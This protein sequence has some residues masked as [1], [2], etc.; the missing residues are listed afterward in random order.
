LNCLNASIHEA[1]K[2][3]SIPLAALLMSFPTVE[4]LAEQCTVT[5]IQLITQV[6]VDNFPTDYPVGC[7]SI[8]GALVIGPSSDIVDLNALSDISQ[9]GYYLRVA[10]N[11]ALTSLDGLNSLLT[12]GMDLVIED[13][14]LLKNI[15][16]LAGVTIVPEMVNINGNPSLKSLTGLQ[17]LTEIGDDLLIDNNDSLLNLDGLFALESVGWNLSV[18]HN[19]K[20]INCQGIRRLIDEIDDYAVGPGVGSRPDVSQSIYIQDNPQHCESLFQIIEQWEAVFKD[21]FE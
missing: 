2:G 19:Q 3:W 11:A 12:I 14:P 5:S 10:D 17:A 6:E 7:N 1:L 16:S 13:N 8:G 15:D 21:S 4:L 18:Q 9:I 20:L